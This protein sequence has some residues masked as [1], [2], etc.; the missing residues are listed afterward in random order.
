MVSLANTVAYPGAMM[1]HSNYTSKNE[2]IFPQKVF[3]LHL[4]NLAVVH[5]WQLYIITI[6]AILDLH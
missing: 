4:A 6:K 2:L 3:P 5:P 1:I